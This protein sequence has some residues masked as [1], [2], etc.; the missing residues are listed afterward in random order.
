MRFVLVLGLVLGLL[1][2]LCASASAAPV[3]RA[4]PRGATCARP[5]R[6]TPQGL[7]GSR[8]DRRTDPPMAELPARERLTPPPPLA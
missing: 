6:Y 7:H 3:H 1:V 8:L 5:T 2:T 4:K